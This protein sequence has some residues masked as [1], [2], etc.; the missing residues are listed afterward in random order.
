VNETI[1]YP[2]FSGR[3]VAVY[4]RLPPNAGPT[5]VAYKSNYRVADNF[6]AASKFPQGHGDAY[7][8]HLTALKAGIGFLRDGPN[9]WPE[10]FLGRIAALAAGTDAGLEAVRHI[11]EAGA[12][13]AQSAHAVTELL[14]RRDYREDPQ[15]PRAAQLFID[16]D[17]ERAWSMGEWARRG[18][19]G[20]YLDWALVAHWSPTDEA[21]PVRRG[22]LGELD[23]LASAVSGLQER[24]DTAGAGLDPL[25]LLPNVVPFGID[26]AGLDSFC[27]MGAQC[28]GSS[29]YQQVSAA[30][31]QA[32]DNARLAFEAA[33]QAGQRLR[34]SDRSFS[35]FAE[36]I[37]DT[38]VDFNQ[39]LIEIFGLPS[40]DDLRDNDLDPA[41]NDFQ[42]SQSAPDLANFLATDDL[43]ASQRMRP[44]PAPGQVQLAISELRV[45]ALGLEKAEL[46]I[47][48]HAASIR[49]Q[50]DRIQIV[51]KVQIERVQI[52]AEACQ[53]Q[54]SLIFEQAILEERKKV[55]G[56]L[57]SGLTNP[58]AALQNLAL[59]IAGQIIQFGLNELVPSGTDFDEQFQI[60]AER[61]RVQCR[62]EA[63]LQGLEDFLEID[64]ERRRLEALVRQTP[65]FIVAR[66][67]ALERATQALGR[68]NQAVARGRRLLKERQRLLSRTEGDLLEER[69]RDMSFRVFRNA[70]LKNYRAF[71]DLGARYVVLSARAYAYEFSRPSSSNQVLAG[72]YRQRRLGRSGSLVGLQGVLTRL[73]GAAVAGNFN[74]PLELLGD[75]RGFSFK[76]NLLGAGF[77]AGSDLR[78]RAWLESQIVERLE[79]LAEVREL[80]RIVPDRDFGPAIV[81]SFS[82]EIDGDRNFFGRGPDPPFGN[83]NFSPTRNVKIRSYAIRFDGVDTQALG[84]DPNSGSVFVFLLPV[85]ESVMREDTN[86]PVLTGLPV[87]WAVV[88]QFLPVPPIAEDDDLARRSF[89][90]WSSTA[91]VQGNYLNAVKRHRDSEAQVDLGQPLR[92]NTNLAG[93]S[94]WNTRWLLIIPGGAWTASS[95]PAEIRRKLLQFIYGSTA[96]P[97]ANRGIFDIRLI[98]QGYSH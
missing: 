2:E 29:H 86:E 36:R 22:S 65:L 60:D 23:E 30:A 43:L 17:R 27:R 83:S 85:G 45:A 9:D 21:R 46:E 98:I 70:A 82:S 33:N 51:S 73:D 54:V 61:V 89:N 56:M 79:I 66:H 91:Q 31:R 34:D 6:E 96:D 92:F 76:Q 20:A 25:G 93:R 71:F 35:D 13:R 3:T 11:A 55:A 48:N 19:A 67:E 72:I 50:M 39:Q 14:Y 8:Y 80:A 78:F 75:G 57:L 40:P 90:P 28:S 88:D 12:A 84:I 44:R 77:E 15:D 74:R 1:Y 41:T 81:I 52:V 47:D 53:E 7:G 32:L 97:A 69:W 26:A 95:N 4:N 18:A 49:S 42:E 24:L 63:R 62:K 38:Q 94:A 58:Q 5:T 87:P 59:D 68:L 37:E 16:P 10:E 64:A